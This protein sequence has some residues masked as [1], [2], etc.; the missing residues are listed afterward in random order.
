[1]M[2]VGEASSSS[3]GKRKVKVHDS[4][5]TQ[6]VLSW[7]VADILNEDLY[8]YQVMDIPESFHSIDQYFGSFIFPL[9]EDIRSK[10]Y[11]CMDEIYK[12]P[13][14]EVTSLKV[15][16]PEENFTYNVKVS[17]WRK[18]G[19]G[20][21]LHKTM[22]GDLVFFS[23][24][25]PE[26][27]SDLHRD[28]RTCTLASVISVTDDGDFIGN[29]SSNQF[30]V[31]AS[32]E[33][34]VKEAHHSLYLVFL[35]NL[36]TE[37]RIWNSLH[38]SCNAKIVKEAIRTSSALN[39]K[40]VFS[41]IQLLFSIICFY[42]FDFVI[43][44][45]QDVEDCK[46]C[47]PMMNSQLAAVCDDIH[48]SGLNQ[49]QSDAIVSSILRTDCSHKP[50]I[51]LIWGPPGT[52]KT[53]TISVFLFH[54]LHM[55]CRTLVCTPTNIA[56]KEIASRTLSLLKD[57]CEETFLLPLGGLLL[58]GNND[59]LKVDGSLED[60]YLDFRV[61]RLTECLGPMTGWRHCLNSTSDFLTDCV[62]QYEVYV[63]NELKQA[64]EESNRERTLSFLEFVRKR[65]TNT[66]SSLKRCIL[67][68]FAH[69]PQNFINEHNKH[70]TR[71]LLH[72]IDQLEGH[73]FDDNVSPEELKK[74]F[75]LF[76]EISYDSDEAIS[77]SQTMRKTASALKDIH[78]FL[79]KLELPNAMIED[80]VKKFCLKWAYLI[81]S[82]ASTSYKLHSLSLEPFK[83]LV[84]DEASQL[85]ECE[86]TIPLQFPGLMHAILVGDERQL[87]AMVTSKVS[88]V[89]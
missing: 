44:I 7:S 18:N 11:S 67:T 72:L 78:G 55:K 87:P 36:L 71:R 86:S 26:Y 63:D 38:K 47:A 49:S 34:D 79:H 70:D 58:F 23:N 37:K 25:K 31:I 61:K 22:P 74:I 33:I 29:D 8:K 27:V 15:S 9:L 54:L 28:G 41:Y 59:R 56:I 46:F 13:F 48:S 3:S 10:L 83:V 19:H 5:F 16:G 81:F 89:T 1:M 60:I 84:I 76:K 65:F 80:S 30:I 68:L 4:G 12:A 85:K 69:L 77:L 51:E 45:K 2:M 24:C 62:P 6:L 42:V 40:M 52:G 66:A 32:N 39:Q 64:K 88:F 50:S 43:V 75:L 20:K 21:E 73:L 14:A 57:S 35:T 82:T 53:K 17:E